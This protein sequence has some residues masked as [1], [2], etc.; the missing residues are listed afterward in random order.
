[1]KFFI[2]T[3]NIGEI[4]EAAGFGMVDGVT[5]NPSLIAREK[6]PFIE[7]VKEIL[8]T[9]SGPVSLEVVSLEAGEM[10]EEGKKLARLGSQVVIKVPMTMDGLKAT[11]LFAAE[12][13]PVN[14]TLIFSPL[15]ALMAAKAG[16]AYVSPFVGRLDDIAHDGMALVEQILNIYNQYGFDTEVIV[17]SVRHPGHVLAAAMMGADIAT[18]PFK[19]IR[20]LAQHPLTDR[21]V[22]AFLSDWRRVPEK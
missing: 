20:Q 13:I 16:A 10:F 19:V 2:D 6:R 1:M 5:T 4:K 3:A 9:V 7:V 14:Q 15:Q 17:A 8:E 11:R 21:G 12:G 18:I 22:E